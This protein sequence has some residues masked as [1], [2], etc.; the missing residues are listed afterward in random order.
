MTSASGM[1]KSLRISSAGLRSCS[2]RVTRTSTIRRAKSGPLAWSGMTSW[3]RSEPARW[4]NAMPPLTSG[5]RCHPLASTYWRALCG[6][7]FHASCSRVLA[8]IVDYLPPRKPRHQLAQPLHGEVVVLRNVDRL[9]RFVPALGRR[10]QTQSVCTPLADQPVGRVN[11]PL[12]AVG[13]QKEHYQQLR[14]LALNRTEFVV[15]LQSYA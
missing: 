13:R 10:P 1:S 4:N 12:R 9:G 8:F 15:V 7:T 6:D 3:S 2:D 11:K 14:C 5:A